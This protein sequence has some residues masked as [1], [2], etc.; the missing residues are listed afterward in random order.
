MPARPGNYDRCRRRTWS[1]CRGG[2]RSRC[3]R[4][5]GSCGRR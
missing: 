4:T 3:R 2:S 1:A 5:A